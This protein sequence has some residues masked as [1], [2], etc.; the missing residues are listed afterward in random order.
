MANSGRGAS[1]RFWCG[2]HQVNEGDGNLFTRLA[3]DPDCALP[4]GVAYIAFQKEKAPSTGRIHY[5]IY[6]ELKRGRYLGWIKKH[7]DPDGHWEVRNGTA[8]QANAYV[9]EE[10]DS[11]GKDKGRIDGPWIFGTMSKGSGSRTDLAALKLAIESGKRKRACFDDHLLTM[12]KYPRFYKEL[13]LLI[14]P[15]MDS[16][17]LT[18][19]E[20]LIGKTGT[21]KTRYARERWP[22]GEL[23]E[24][25]VQGGKTTWFD[26][27]D[28]HIYALFDEFTGK[29]KLDNLLKVIDVYPRK[30]EIKG[31]HVW[32]NPDV[33]L[34][35]SNLHPARWYNWKGREEHYDALCRRFSTVKI[36]TMEPEY[37]EIP[38]NNDPTHVYW[39]ENYKEYVTPWVV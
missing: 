20:L 31:G 24:V 39:T 32:F 26:G 21:G 9:T 3:S 33:I 34:I 7:V 19:V 25:P 5:Q 35:T 17:N 13:N 15:D 23:F 11:K 2:T 4:E 30:V 16:D 22:K 28:Q 12:C 10:T 37:S 8:D 18:K 1:R 29:M 36:F 14:E 38:V 27:Y 6:M